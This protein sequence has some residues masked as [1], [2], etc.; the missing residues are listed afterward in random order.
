ML[1]RETVF[2]RSSDAAVL[3]AHTGDPVPRVE[4]RRPELPAAL[5][6]VFE[7]ALAEEPGERPGSATAVVR[8]VERALGPE[9][10]AAL[11]PPPP[12]ARA[13]QAEDE[14]VTPSPPGVP[15]PIR[16]ALRRRS[17]ARLVVAVAVAARPSRLWLRVDRQRL[18]GRH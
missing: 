13:A 8:A 6:E 7:R 10:I 5:D 14:D 17:G 2:P 15:R 4:A 16:R 11:G 1:D 3:Y 12:R 18:L 9:A